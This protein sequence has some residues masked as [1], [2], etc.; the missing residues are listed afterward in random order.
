M[1]TLFRELI[2]PQGEMITFLG[3]LLLFPKER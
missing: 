3:E 2:I 1:I